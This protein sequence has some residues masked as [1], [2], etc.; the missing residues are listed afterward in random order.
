MKVLAL[1]PGIRGCGVALFNGGLLE[2]CAYVKN[3]VTSGDGPEAVF[4]MAREVDRWQPRLAADTVR[5][6]FEHPRIYTAAKSKGDN[7]DLMP[8]VAV[9]Y[10][11]AA[12]FP[13]R[14]RVYPHEWKGTMPKSVCAARVLARLD[15]AERAEAELGVAPFLTTKSLDAALTDERWKGHNVL[16]AVGIGLKHVGRFEPKHSWETT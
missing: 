7:N 16:D 8:L 13:A 5:L 15:G 1:D 12:R 11:V 10:A 9:D 14:T 3:P 2:A 6:V 4:A